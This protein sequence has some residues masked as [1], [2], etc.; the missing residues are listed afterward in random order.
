MNFTELDAFNK[1]QEA[2]FEAVLATALVEVL[3]KNE[4]EEELHSLLRQHVERMIEITRKVFPTIN[5]LG[6]CQA[7][8]FSEPF[9]PSPSRSPPSEKSQTFAEFM[10]EMNA[11][12]HAPTSFEQCN[13]S[14]AKAITAPT[15]KPSQ[16]AAKKPSPRQPRDSSSNWDLS[17]S[18]GDSKPANKRTTRQTDTLLQ[19]TPTPLSSRKTQP[20]VS[21]TPVRQQTTRRRSFNSAPKSKQPERGQLGGANK[22]FG[23]GPVTKPSYDRK[24]KP[25]VVH[26]VSSSES[27]GAQAEEFEEESDEGL[28]VD[29]RKAKNSSVRGRKDGKRAARNRGGDVGKPKEDWMTSHILILSDD[30][31]ISKTSFD[32]DVFIETFG[33]SPASKKRKRNTATRPGEFRN[34]DEEDYADSSPS[35]KQKVDSVMDEPERTDRPG[36]EPLSPQKIASYVSRSVLSIQEGP[37]PISD[38]IAGGFTSFRPTV[39]TDHEMEEEMMKDDDAE[40]LLPQI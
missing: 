17:S 33:K 12:S 20:Q 29:Q 5:V 27:E 9:T 38:D 3:S 31:D 26:I 15:N 34:I 7:K 1:T 14:A 21:V 18:E 11:N 40:E 24:K 39:E 25:E 35:K 8:I 28:F 10:E 30:D 2:A 13:D 16:K 22:L 6:R 19:N 23:G 37:L 32:A 36:W 4:L